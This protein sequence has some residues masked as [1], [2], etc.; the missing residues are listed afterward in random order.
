MK[1]ELVEVKYED[2]E[3]LRNLLELYQ[4]DSSEFNDDEIQ[5]NGLFGY[6]YLDH[7]WTEDGRYAYFIK[8]DSKLAG[9]AMVRCFKEGSKPIN[10]M[11]EFFI[12]RKY[13]R[14]GLGSHAAKKIFSLFPGIWNVGQ[15]EDNLPAQKFWCKV[16]GEYTN[17]NFKEIHKNYWQ[18]PIQEFEIIQDKIRK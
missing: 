1:I 10:S 4:Y 11:A 5:E 14:S 18:G 3:I 9:L 7:Y 8:K 6:K 12:M 2:K 15:E 16:I 13:R 17:N